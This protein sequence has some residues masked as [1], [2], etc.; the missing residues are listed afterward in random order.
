MA[1]REMIIMRGSGTDTD[2]SQRGNASG[3]ISPVVMGLVLASSAT[4]TISHSVPS[5]TLPQ[6]D[7]QC[8]EKIN[9]SI[10]K[11]KIFQRFHSTTGYR[12]TCTPSEHSEGTVS[13]FILTKRNGR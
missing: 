10:G 6:T 3:D 1:R 7:K 8:L 12:A 2:I 5:I 13:S 4:W 11:T 9:E